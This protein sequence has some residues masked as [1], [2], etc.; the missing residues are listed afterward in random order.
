MQV[1]TFKAS[2]EEKAAIQDEAK[3]R[4]LD[5]TGLIRLALATLTGRPEF[6]TPRR[7]G[8]PRGNRHNPRGRFIKGRSPLTWERLLELAAP[9]SDRISDE[10]DLL[11]K[12]QRGAGG[13]LYVHPYLQYGVAPQ[14]QMAIKQD[15]H[16]PVV[17][18][19]SE[20]EATQVIALGKT[21]LLVH[22]ETAESREI[23][24]TWRQ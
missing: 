14:L 3:R 7:T 16:H 24:P 17:C 8:A 5:K 15:P 4:G 10:R 2:A 1:E 11:L 20:E 12:W 13:Y 18:V 21:A 23:L 6:T 9:P 22:P 19:R